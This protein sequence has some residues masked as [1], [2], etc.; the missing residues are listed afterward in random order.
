M[1]TPDAVRPVPTYQQARVCED[2]VSTG[3]EVETNG[4]QLKI[5]VVGTTNG[6]GLV[7]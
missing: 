2:Q 5:K 1:R 4:D 6:H 7:A 3:G